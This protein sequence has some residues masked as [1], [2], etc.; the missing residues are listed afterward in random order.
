MSCVPRRYHVCA[1]TRVYRLCCVV[2][3]HVFRVIQVHCYCYV[4]TVPVL[5]ISCHLQ[6]ALVPNTK[7]TRSCPTSFHCVPQVHKY[8]SVY[9]KYIPPFHLYLRPLPLFFF[10]RVFFFGRGTADTSPLAALR[11][12]DRILR[13]SLLFI[14]CSARRP[15]SSVS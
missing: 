15:R 12:S 4:F 3:V 6:S 1:H 5:C 11:I 10:R 2:H 14:S 13:S 7:A 9:R 8:T